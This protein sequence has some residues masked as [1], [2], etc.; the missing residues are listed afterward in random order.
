MGRTWLAK[1]SP[2]VVVVVVLPALEVRWKREQGRTE[3]WASWVIRASSAGAI[4]DDA[5]RLG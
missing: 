3:L 5:G 4:L 1:V 2:T